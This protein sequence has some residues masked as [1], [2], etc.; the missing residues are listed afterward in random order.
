MFAVWLGV[1]GW[2]LQSLV[3]FGLYI[4]ALAWPAFTFLG[5]LRQELP[6]RPQAPRRH[7]HQSTIHSTNPAKSLGFAHGMR[8]LFLNGPN[9]NLL[10]QR[11]PE[12]YGR[13]DFGRH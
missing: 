8:I 2:S 4:P 6:R 10:G 13:A 5:W 11:E 1:L 9:L 12:V 3:E 7:G